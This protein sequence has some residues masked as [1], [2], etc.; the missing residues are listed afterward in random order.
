MKQAHYL[1]HYHKKS[2]SYVQLESL[3]LNHNS[4]NNNISNNN[5]KQNNQHLSNNQTINNNQP[6]I[7]TNM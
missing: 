5:I 4:F 7:S 2:P 6:D 1:P 3:Y